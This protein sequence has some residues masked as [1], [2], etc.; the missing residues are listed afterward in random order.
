ME[1]V[2]TEKPSEPSQS[3]QP[4]QPSQP[5][6]PIEPM[7]PMEPMETVETV[8]TAEPSE[9]PEA[10]EGRFEKAAGALRRSLESAEE[11]IR[12]LQLARS[13]E[14]S[15]NVEL[16]RE[17]L[18]LNQA[19]RPQL[20]PSVLPMAVSEAVEH[21]LEGASTDEVCLETPMTVATPLDLEGAGV[22]ELESG[23]AEELEKPARP[24][25]DA[26]GEVQDDVAPRKREAEEMTESRKSARV[27]NEGSGI[28][29][30]NLV[31]LR[32]R[33]A[34]KKWF[35]AQTKQWA[36]Q[37][38]AMVDEGKSPQDIFSEFCEQ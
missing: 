17:L 8:E 32:C 27:E 31:R 5:I 36:A 19:L 18:R 20:E 13:V 2:E 35:P 10:A 33:F 22:S 1:T 38:K 9:P 26:Q 15:R 16:R 7:E 37:F 30:M 25:G 28:M 6:E 21:P 34:L 23:G 24:A 14:K 12:W 3:S 29:S 4:S 11:S